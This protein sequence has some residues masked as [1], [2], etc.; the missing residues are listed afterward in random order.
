MFFVSKVW[1]SGTVVTISC[2]LVAPNHYLTRRRVTPVGVWDFGGEQGVEDD[3]FSAGD[4][5]LRA[6]EYRA[7]RRS[8][9]HVVG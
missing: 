9:S 3:G 7:R 8:R 2:T 4:D 6:E 1:R 5:L